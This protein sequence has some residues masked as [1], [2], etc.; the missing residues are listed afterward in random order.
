VKCEYVGGNYFDVLG[1]AAAEGRT[2]APDE[3]GSAGSQPVVVV[4]ENF[5]RRRFGDKSPIG[6]SLTLNNVP[7]TI[8]G[9]APAE[10]HGMVLEEPTDIWVPVLM[11]LN[12]ASQ[13]S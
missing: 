9:V 6:I 7:L 13:S 4:S 10:F 2:F 12:F 1:V 8:V 3:D 5:R 11:H